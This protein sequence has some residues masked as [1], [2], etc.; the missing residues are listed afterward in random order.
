MNH[1]GTSAGSATGSS[2]RPDDRG[3]GLHHLTP[4]PPGG[5]ASYAEGGGRTPR[6]RRL[7]KWSSSWPVNVVR[8]GSCLRG[9]GGDR[10]RVDPPERNVLTGTF[11][12][13][14]SLTPPGPRRSCGAPAGGAG[15][16]VEHRTERAMRPSARF[17]CSVKCGAG[18]DAVYGP[19]H[20]CWFG[21]VL[22]DQVVAQGVVVELGRRDRIQA[23]GGVSSS[24]HFSRSRNAAPVGPVA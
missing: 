13:C 8:S 2:S 24:R 4:Y 15:F 20:R 5:H 7:Q 16:V 6:R 23:E 1:S 12:L 18:F 14:I 9:E 3:G 11:T 10:G 17:C 22:E 19:V 21:H